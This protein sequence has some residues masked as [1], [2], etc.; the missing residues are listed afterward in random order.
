MFVKNQT[1]KDEETLLEILFDFDLGTP[2]SIITEKR[3]LIEED[4]KDN[5]ALRDYLASLDD[6]EERL[7]VA[8]EERYIRLAEYLMQDFDSFK[9]EKGKLYGIKAGAQSLLSEMDI[10]L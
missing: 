6:E 8:T 3:K 1:F 10:E 5:Q 7:E 4:L 2:S 9:V